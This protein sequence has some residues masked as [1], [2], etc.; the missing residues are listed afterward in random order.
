MR[1]SENGSVTTKQSM[2]AG[3]IQT[4]KDG[5][6]L[7]NRRSSRTNFLIA[8]FENLHAQSID[9]FREAITRISMNEQ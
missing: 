9:T 6:L 2:P 7:S 8:V 5:R 1:Q 3:Y 4:E